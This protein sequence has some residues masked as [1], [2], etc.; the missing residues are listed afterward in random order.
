[1]GDLT[2]ADLGRIEER[3]GRATPGP[4]C[5]G[6]WVIFDEDRVAQR[7][8]EPYWTLIEASY[9]DTLSA[10]PFGRKAV[11]MTNVI[12]PEGYETDGLGAK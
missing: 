2:L 6:M 4:W 1:M 12:W 3:A 7:R 5:W 8:G 9:P 11:E 10:G